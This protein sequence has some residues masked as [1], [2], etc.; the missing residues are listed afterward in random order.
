MRLTAEELAVV[1]QGD[2]SIVDAGVLV[3]GHGERR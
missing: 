1:K 3:W 2:P